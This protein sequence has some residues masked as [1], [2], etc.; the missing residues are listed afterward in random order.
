[1]IGRR[2]LLASGIAFGMVYGAG[3]ATQTQAQ[4]Y[5]DKP[6][7][8]IVPFPPGGP[9]DTMARLTGQDLSTR[10]GQQVIVENRPGAGSTIGYKAAAAADPDGYTLLFGSSGSLAVAPALYPSLDIDPLKHFA[11]VATTSL[12]PHVMVVGPGVPA[13][14]VAEFVAYA[15]A[16]AG[17]LNYGAGLGTPP[18]LLSTLFKTQ[19]GLDITYVPYKGSAPSVTDLLGGQTHFT[20]DGMLILIPQVKQGKLRALAV[21]RPERWP[22][23]PNV[24][25]F[26]ESGFSD[27][28]I[29]AWTGVVAPKGTPAPV[30]AKLNAAINEGLKTDEI[31]AAL[32]KF[33]AL[34]RAG[35][36]QEFDAFLREQL[37]KWASMVKLAG[38]K[39][40]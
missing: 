30:I 31:K 39:G 40:E 11:P 28:V 5:P 20:I 24:P 1:M 13:N 15:K 23:L 12:L 35:S 36:P 6:I 38:A 2:A 17:K 9:I 8:M 18:H 10:L 4:S 22:D 16:N 26:V 33:S 19:A 7:K 25:T 37:P 34:P 32:T 21:A 29:D 3:F 27:L 14:T